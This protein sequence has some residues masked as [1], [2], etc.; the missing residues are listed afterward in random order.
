MKRHGGLWE[1]IARR[2]IRSK[3]IR[4]QDEMKQ[5]VLEA[6]VVKTNNPDM[7]DFHQRNGFL[8]E[9]RI[10]LVDVLTKMFTLIWA[11]SLRD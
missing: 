10:T 9:I 11:L 7:E 8:E 5:L 3:R 2:I 6:T 1:A 4:R